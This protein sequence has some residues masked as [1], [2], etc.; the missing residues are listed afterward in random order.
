[1]MTNRF[2]IKYK[3]RCAFSVAEVIIAISILGVLAMVFAS[4]MTH[5]LNI[6]FSQKRITKSV[7]DLQKRIEREIEAKR[8][9]GGL[10]YSVASDV[11]LPGHHVEYSQIEMEGD[12]HA[13]YTLVSK[14]RQ[15]KEEI[16]ECVSAKLAIKQGTQQKYLSYAPFVSSNSLYNVDP[17]TLEC[18]YILNFNKMKNVSLIS[19][20]WYASKNAYAVPD[21][22]GYVKGG[23]Y[24]LYPSFPE[25][26]ELISQEVTS[27]TDEWV[28]VYKGDISDLAGRHVVLKITPTT[29]LGMF[30][31]AAVSN[32][33]YVHPLPERDHLIL[34]LDASLMK[35]A[36]VSG[37]FVLSWQDH[38]NFQKKASVGGSGTVR[39]IK[40]YES[41]SFSGYGVKLKPG[42]ILKSPIDAQS[43]DLVTVFVFSEKPFPV[44]ALKLDSISIKGDYSLADGTKLTAM[45]G[46]IKNDHLFEISMEEEIDIY[47]I[48]VYKSGFVQGVADKIK[49]YTDKKFNPAEFDLSA[50]KQMIDFTSYA[51][52]GEDYV[53]PSRATAILMNGKRRSVPV[54]W[55]LTPPVEKFNLMPNAIE[56]E[57][58]GHADSDSSKTVKMKVIAPPYPLKVKLRML[59]K[60][61]VALFKGRTG[62]IAYEV[63]GHNNL[64]LP[65]GVQAKVKFK[66]SNPS[67]MKL[68][69][70]DGQ[71][72]SE[73]EVDGAEGY[74]DISGE[75]NGKAKLTMTSF[76][77]EKAC[78]VDVFAS[79][80]PLAWYDSRTD[81]MDTEFVGL[82][83]N[84][85]QKIDI[86][87]WKD[88]SGQS[89]DMQGGNA[90]GRRY[91]RLDPFDKAVRIAKDRKDMLFCEGEFGNLNFNKNVVAGKSV[92]ST[93]V[94]VVRLSTNNN[95]Q[96]QKNV[97]FSQSGKDGFGYSVALKHNGNGS[98]TIFVETGT[99]AEQKK[100]LIVGDLDLGT[101][102]N[103]RMAV[104]LTNEEHSGKILVKCIPI[105]SAPNADPIA[106]DTGEISKSDSE[107]SG[108]AIG[109]YKHNN[110][111]LTEFSGVIYEFMM[112]D[113]VLSES[114]IKN[115]AKYLKDKWY[116][117]E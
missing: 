61:G 11:F 94:Y 15:L 20:Q 106:V 87:V 70:H 111:Y 98:K 59:P 21:V 93:F 85:N 65:D 26:Y 99:G 4:F 32:P 14:E 16:P 46:R 101:N 76:Q 38:S 114:E 104:I 31:H 73:F 22:K 1:M 25:D 5:S 79:I 18:A 29:Y 110:S 45:E 49:D 74:V 95:S 48:I 58:V 27:E 51:T 68:I 60:S 42:D 113:R 91:P 30:G 92:D 80:E 105:H 64:P 24:G 12:S 97:V 56:Y 54:S 40:G 37:D 28:A 55:T 77:V 13:F 17:Y 102:T 67:I 69:N 6:Q 109:G 72:V 57:Y 35:S 39:L 47:E 116:Q 86:K 117:T 62:R 66:S 44:D 63:I 112:F 84:G 2:F 36:D 108:F 53:P 34:H 82:D 107:V 9:D 23:F 33:V 96:S 71:K 41:G 78:D 43:G 115:L 100:E 103:G 75:E 89:Y 10:V 50:V 83:T 3:R 8:A 7:F 90:G 52:P 19:Y 81:Y 88:Y